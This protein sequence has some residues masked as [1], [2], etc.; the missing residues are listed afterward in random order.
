MSCLLRAQSHERALGF[1]SVE[2]A[3]D[4]GG[5]DRELDLTDQDDVC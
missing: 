1:Q 4:V 5:T 3:G 2:Q